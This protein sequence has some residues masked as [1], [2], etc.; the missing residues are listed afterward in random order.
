MSMFLKGM[1]LAEKYLSDAKIENFQIQEMVLDD[2][3]TR[4][5][6]IQQLLKNFLNEKKLYTSS[7]TLVE[8]ASFGAA[9]QA[10]ILIG[11][12]DEKVQELLV[13]DATDLGLKSAGGMMIVLI[14]RNATRFFQST[15]TIS[16]IMLQLKSSFI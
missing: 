16:L 5:Q 2:G 10:A 9:V 13:V 12:Q 1:E 14:S 3:S 8:V 7:I 6:K 4:I 11:K 15:Q